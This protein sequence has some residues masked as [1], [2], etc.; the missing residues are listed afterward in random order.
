MDRRLS[1]ALPL[2]SVQHEQDG[3]R[4]RLLIVVQNRGRTPLT[5]S[6]GG[7]TFELP[8]GTKRYVVIGYK[9]PFRCDPEGVPVRYVVTAPVLRHVL[10]EE[11][12]ENSTHAFVF[13]GT[14]SLVSELP[15]DSRLLK[16]LLDDAED[17]VDQTFKVIDFHEDS[18]NERELAPI[19]GIPRSDGTHALTDGMWMA[20]L[21]VGEKQG[22]GRGR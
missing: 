2:L 9:E 7:L 12:I 16:L 1:G 14:G 18:V 20:F 11:S 10:T 8:N 4:R 17:D 22:D 19:P 13:T 5:L 21:R 3:G 15:L 6:G